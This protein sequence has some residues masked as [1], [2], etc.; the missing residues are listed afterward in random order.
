MTVVVRTGESSSSGIG[1]SWAP[2]IRISSQFGIGSSVPIA[3]DWLLPVT[4]ISWISFMYRQ[5]GSSR[6]NS[7]GY[8]S[9]GSLGRTGS[10]PW[11]SLYRVNFSVGWWQTGHSPSAEKGAPSASSS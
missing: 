8:S 4:A 5:A 1:S 7:F 10:V 11:S 3:A 6:T 2:K 9:L